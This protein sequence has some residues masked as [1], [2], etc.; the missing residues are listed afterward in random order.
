VRVNGCVGDEKELFLGFAFHHHFGSSLRPRFSF[1]VYVTFTVVVFCVFFITRTRLNFKIVLHLGSIPY[2]YFL[3]H[4]V[5][6]NEKK[7]K[8]YF[9]CNVIKCVEKKVIF[10]PCVLRTFL[11]RIPCSNY[12]IREQKTGVFECVYSSLFFFSE[13]ESGI[14]LM[15]LQYFYFFYNYESVPVII[16]CNSFKIVVRQRQKL[17]TERPKD[18]R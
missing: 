6:R 18:R 17:E 4:T 9:L 8:L 14:N 5:K 13:S 16:E 1:F 12:T 7:L 3:L 10:S 15:Y 2:M 11:L